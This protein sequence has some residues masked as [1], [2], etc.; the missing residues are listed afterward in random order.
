MNSENKKAYIWNT[1]SGVVSAIQSAIVLIFI[2][3]YLGLTDAGTFTIAYAIANLVGVFAKYGMRNFQVTDIEEQYSF[4]CYW[5]ARMISV[6]ASGIFLIV[7]LALQIEWHSYTVNKAGVILGICV[8][9]LIDAVEDV[10]IGAYQ[11]RGKL[12]T[13]ACYYTLRLCFSTGLY[14]VLIACRVNLVCATGIMVGISILI[15]I[16]FCTVSFPEF[17][18][19]DNN[20]AFKMIVSLMRTGLP[21]CIGTTLANYI[22]NAPKYTIDRY[23][24]DSSQAYFGYI[25]MPAFVI[26]LFSNFIYQPLVRNLGLLWSEGDVKKFFHAV[27]R[28]FGIV[29]GIT[30]VA[31]MMGAWLGIPVLSFI[32]GVNLSFLK[33]EFLLLMIG[34]GAYA[35]VSYLTVILTTI[36]MQ[37]WQAGGFV[38]A[39]LLYSIL[40]KIFVDRW[41]ILGV[42]LLY[43]S[44]NVLL[45]VTFTTCMLLKTK[46]RLNRGRAGL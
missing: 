14:C 40:G 36:R 26:L 28:Q 33:R 41:E 17:K 16:C 29:M 10:F 11:Q 6:A 46:Y 30:I 34:G 43:L 1:A 35:L 19:S 44:V 2:S 4:L 5:K 15:C 38:I 20:A 27:F 12:S 45:I 13:G 18:I 9:K 21:L 7:Y 24:G 22:G 42:A 25:M 8:W 32:Y 39:A 3:R 37:N 31:V 23:M